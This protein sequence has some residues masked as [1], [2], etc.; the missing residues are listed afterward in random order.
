[1]PASQNAP[2]RLLVGR[3]P[4]SLASRYP[5]LVARFWS[6]LGLVWDDDHRLGSTTERIG[7]MATWLDRFAPTSGRVLEVGCGTGSCA[8]ALGA[9]H[10]RVVAT[11]VATG[12]VR[13]AW[14]RARASG[15]PVSVVQADAN[16]PLPF[17]DDAFDA[18]VCM[19]VLDCVDSPP[20]FLADVRRALRPHGLLLLTIAGMGRTARHRPTLSGWLLFALRVLPGSKHRIS[21]CTWEELLALLEGSGYA[22]LDERDTHSSVWRDSRQVALVAKAG[23]DPPGAP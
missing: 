6:L 12:M 21:T 13:R 22:V 17:H 18:V 2:P 5:R 7:L 3:S 16:A 15:A 19:A 8:L 4:A 11:D 20:R 10:R 14:A 23:D 1:M 9:P